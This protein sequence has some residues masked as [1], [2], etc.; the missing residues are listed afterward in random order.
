MCL[1]LPTVDGIG[2]LINLEPVDA[3]LV[4]ED[5]QVV[6]GRSDEEVFDEILRARAHADAAFAAARLPPVGIDR[7]ALQIPAMRDGHR[8]V[9][10]RDQI[11]Q[12]DL[13]RI[14]DD[15]RAALVAVF[16]L[17]FPAVP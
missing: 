6:V 8:H 12:P 3:A 1:P 2:N 13:A 11:F 17:D 7:R 14:V 15:L 10:H 5:Q 9:F 16:L 4:G